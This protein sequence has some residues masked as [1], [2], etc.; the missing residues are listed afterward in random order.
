MKS[1]IARALDN[2]HTSG[3]A[4]IYVAAK[5]GAELGAIW[6]PAHKDQFTATSNAIEACAVGWGLLMAGDAKDNP[7]DKPL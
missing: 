6:F 7:P 5:F 2:K 1:I 4:L 3:A